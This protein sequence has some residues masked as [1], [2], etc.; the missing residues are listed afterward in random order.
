MRAMILSIASVVL[1]AWAA[2]AQ[3]QPAPLYDPATGTYGV[4][5][6]YYYAYAPSPMGPRVWGPGGYYSYQPYA[7][8]SGQSYGYNTYGSSP[9][10]SGYYPGYTTY[11]YTYRRF[12]PYGQ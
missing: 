12:R 8:N 4:A 2:P 1:L 11:T 9:S 7:Y 5:P 6:S 10:Y 3:A